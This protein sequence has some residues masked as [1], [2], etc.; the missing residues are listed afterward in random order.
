VAAYNLCSR[1]D[2]RGA[3]ASAYDRENVAVLALAA[4][5]GLVVV[6]CNGLKANGHAKFRGLEKEFLHNLPR[7]S[8]V[9]ADED[10]K[11]QR[12]MDIG[13]ADVQDLGVIT[14]QDIHY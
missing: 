14:R 10:S 13:L 1:T 9:Y 11:G 6:V 8:L 3:E 5:P 2:L 4:R 7:R 12:A